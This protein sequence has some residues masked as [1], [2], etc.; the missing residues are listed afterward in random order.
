MRSRYLR[1][2]IYVKGRDL[3]SRR[4]TGCPLLFRNSFLSLCL[5]A[6][7]SYEWCMTGR[8]WGG[9]G[10]LK[11]VQLIL[12]KHRPPPSERHINSLTRTAFT[13][14]HIIILTC[15]RYIQFGLETPT[16]LTELGGKKDFPSSWA[17]SDP[18]NSADRDKY[19]TTTVVLKDWRFYSTT[20]LHKDVENG[21]TFPTT[22]AAVSR[23]RISSSSNCQL[24]QAN[25]VC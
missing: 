19:C 4:R 24:F 3:K 10:R 11:S 9:W 14:T 21:L 13:D 23:V 12:S 16:D 5:S 17:H 1:Q 20:V 2:I 25:H 15:T 22:A 8:G 18:G 7:F 6:P